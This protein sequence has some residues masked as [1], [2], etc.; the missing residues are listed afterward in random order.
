[1]ETIQLVL[2]YMP[3]NYYNYYIFNLLCS[4]RSGLPNGVQS[5]STCG[6]YKNAELQIHNEG[7]NNKCM[8]NATSGHKMKNCCTFL[9]KNTEKHE[10]RRTYEKKD[11]SV[12]SSHEGTHGEK[13]E[14]PQ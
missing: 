9:S 5:A 1:M 10:K 3:T 6:Q 12:K 2:N 13:P 8:L 7:I 11:I 14:G 4:C